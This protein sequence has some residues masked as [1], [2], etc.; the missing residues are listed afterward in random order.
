M[1]ISFRKQGEKLVFE[2]DGDD[3][4]KLVVHIMPFVSKMGFG[5]V[6]SPSLSLLDTKEA[7]NYLGVKVGTLNVWRVKGQRRIP[8][9]KIGRRI[10]Y[11]LRDLEEYVNER[12]G[13]K[14]KRERKK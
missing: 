7:A 5:N 9:V 4:A 10:Q 6:S 11:R 12:T 3:L 8:Y 14:P 13:N 2:L 1:A